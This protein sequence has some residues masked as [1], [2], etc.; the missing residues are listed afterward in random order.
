MKA[1][2]ISPYGFTCQ[3]FNNAFKDDPNYSFVHY[4]YRQEPDAP[5]HPLIKS[6]KEMNEILLR[7]E[8]DIAI[9]TEEHHYIV[10]LDTAKK[11][12]KKLFIKQWDTP[13]A[14]SSNLYVNFRTAIKQPRK[15][16]LLDQPVPVAEFAQYCNFLVT[17][18]GFGEVYPN[19]Y[20]VMGPMNLDWYYYD[21][22]ITRDIEVS[23][24]GTM[25]IPERFKY[26][27][28]F[29]KANLNIPIY[30]GLHGHKHSQNL[31]APDYANIFQRTKITLGFTESVFG[32]NWRT[33]KD[34]MYV[35]AA[36][37]SLALLT[38]PETLKHRNGNWFEEGVHF[39]SINESN[40]VDKI[41]Y[42]MENQDIAR[43]MA[44]AA[45]NHFKENYNPKKWWAE[46]F[47]RVNDK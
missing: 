47:S 20:A 8:F 1:L 46:V 19:I 26:F 7:E 39:D 22:N 9:V 2:I 4:W 3:W 13:C 21:E 44:L 16:G 43:S 17:D 40:A 14:I 18:Y 31:T 35:S 45:N 42:Y 33:R 32:P 38:H 15:W 5:I 29:K 36:C 23:F 30:G 11:L 24:C 41:I 10:F 12:G 34:K 25:Y 37:G 6:A 27:E 28:I